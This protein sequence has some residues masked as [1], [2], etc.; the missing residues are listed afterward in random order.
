MTVFKT[1][2]KILRK[3]LAMI[4]VYTIILVIIDIGLTSQVY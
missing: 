1:F 2:L 4:I 3:N